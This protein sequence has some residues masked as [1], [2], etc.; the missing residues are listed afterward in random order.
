MT[1][2]MASIGRGCPPEGNAGGAW[3][4]SVQ[5]PT[6]TQEGSATPT[7]PAT[8]RLGDCL[9]RPSSPGFCLRVIPTPFTHVAP[10]RVPQVG[11]FI[12]RTNASSAGT[13]GREAPQA[14]GR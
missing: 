1:A 9:H 10:D 4:G 5:D 8:L 7:N 14:P 11:D 3:A 6:A 2:R 13:L 12:R